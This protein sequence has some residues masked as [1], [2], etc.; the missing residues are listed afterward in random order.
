[1][2]V[3]SGPEQL[4]A[5]RKHWDGKQVLDLLDQ[6]NGRLRI[7]WAVGVGKSH[8]I[9]L[10]IAEAIRSERYD[11]VIALFPTR[12]VIEERKWIVTPPEEIKVVNL[13]PRPVNRCGSKTNRRWQ[14]FE[15]N[16]LGAYGRTEL[17]GHC[18][19]RPECSWPNQ[20]GRSLKGSQVIYC[21]QTH[22]ERS[23]DFL[24]QIA[25]WAAA[26]R[27]LVILDEANFVMKSF[28]RRINQRE[29]QIFT[30]VLEQLDPH[31][32]RKYHDRW[33]YLCNL[34]LAAQ[35]PD[36]R[37]QEW[38]FPQMPSNWSLAVQVRGYAIYGDS[39]CFL[40][41]DLLH[42]SQSPLE[43]RERTPN[44]DILFA[45][46]PNISMD[47]IV[48]SGTADHQ[49]AQYRLGSEFA[50]PFK[51]YQFI[52]PETVWFNIA[53]R[54]GAKQYFR[55]N[56]KQILDFFAGLV[57][58]RLQEGKRP[59]L[60][61]KK[62]FASFCTRE[63]EERLGRLGMNIRVVTSGWHRE[64]LD[65][66]NTVPLI[67]FG[68]IG[69]N[70]FQEFDCAYCLTGYYVTED[71]V[72]GILQDL[73]GS[74][75]RIPMRIIIEGRPCRR[76]AGVLNPK[77][78]I[79][80][81]HALSQHALDHLEMD[82]V[83]QAV[84]R[85]RPYTKPREVITFQCASHPDLDYTKEFASIGEARNYFDIPGRRSAQ[86][87]ELFARIQEARNKGLKQIEAAE[88]LGIGLRSVQRYWKSNPPPTLI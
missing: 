20:F 67:S 32:W 4:S 22:L 33:R 53:S 66:P 87:A 35:T 29:L 88:Q 36:L 42:F 2:V 86:T 44:G 56:S 54:M 70:L 49:F 63:I 39:L 15:K 7:E 84:G 12:Q 73:L 52:H 31:R 46:V 8:N 28:H 1:M 14:V 23:P 57:S 13:Q 80:D 34:L 47:F 38:R 64:L 11:L 62:C 75:M 74:D 9:D 19:Y 17:C 85:V 26:Q 18:L 79:Y 83:L 30:E 65:A 51:E 6:H 69:T 40:A 60:I 78:R 10:T 16:G 48:Y 71:A 82:T 59:L 43:S 50:S 24:N 37:S 5:F 3:V 21:T 25:R 68:M 81:I 72:D 55:Q 45:A 27:V 58:R 76:R 61:A 41:Y 77:D